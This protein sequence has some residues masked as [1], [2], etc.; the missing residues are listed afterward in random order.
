MSALTEPLFDWSSWVTDRDL[1]R[2]AI[3][4]ALERGQWDAVRKML[5]AQG[6][7]DD[8]LRLWLDKRIVADNAQRRKQ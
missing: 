8:R 4:E 1:R 6:E 5:K 2:R 7:Q 3:D